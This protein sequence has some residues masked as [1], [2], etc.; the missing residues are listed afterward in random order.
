MATA[1]PQQS[2]G[3]AITV[4]SGRLNTATLLQ[5]RRAAVL[6]LR[7][8]AKDYPASVASECL[9]NLITSLSNDGEDVDTVQAV[10]QT[11]LNFLQPN[12]NSLEAPEAAEDITLWVADEFAL[13]PENMALLLSFLE[14]EDLFSRLYTLQLLHMILS[15]RTARTEEAILAAP[16]GLHRLVA[17]LGDKRDV[18]RN[19]GIA[20]LTALTQDSSEL[21]KIAVFNDAFDWIFSII[22]GEGGLSDGDRVIEDCLIL[23]GNLLRNNDPNAITFREAGCVPHLAKLL[24][25]AHGLGNETEELATW[26]LEQQERNT[27]ALLAITRLFLRSA[28]QRQLNQQAFYASDG[29]YHALQLAF[30][31]AADTSIRAQALI[32]CAD[33]IA[34]NPRLQERFPQLQVP[35]VTVT[36]TDV[37]N[38][39]LS[40]KSVTLVYVIDALLEFAL[41]VQ[42]PAMF[43][44]RM[45]ACQCLKAYFN[46]HDEIRR[47]FVQQAVEGYRLGNPA[48][49]NV[50]AILAEDWFDPDSE[51]S[52]DP[53][54][55]WFAAVLLLNL[56]GESWNSDI[57]ESAATNG[58]SRGAKS[59]PPR[60]RSIMMNWRQTLGLSNNRPALGYSMLITTWLFKNQ[61]GIN[62]FLEEPENLDSLIAAV[63]SGDQGDILVQGVCAVMLGI[64]YD[65][66]TQESPVTRH[67]L[68]QIIQAKVTPKRFLDAV[69]SLRS[70]PSIRD[71]DD[72]PHKAGDAGELPQVYFDE[73]YVA[74]FQTYGDM[75]NVAIERGPDS[76][77]EITE[78]GEIIYVNR[79]LVEALRK[80]IDEKHSQWQ[81]AESRWGSIKQQLESERAEHQRHA[82]ELGRITGVNDALQR[83]HEDEVKSLQRKQEEE[84]R[85]LQRQIEDAARQNKDLTK[86]LENRRKDIDELQRKYEESTRG[87]QRKDDEIKSTR[88]ANQKQIE[89]MRQEA[90]KT[91]EAANAEAAEKAAEIQRQLDYL[92]KSSEAEAKRI[93]RRTEAEVADLR[94]TI[95]RQ[96]VE[97]M[98]TSKAHSQELQSATQELQT[99]KQELQTVKQ[100][101]QTA[102][103]ELKTAKQELQT[104]KQE[105]TTKDKKIKEVEQ[106]LRQLQ[107]K[108]DEAQKAGKQSRQQQDKKAEDKIREL[109]SKL[110]DAEKRKAQ[111][112][113]QVSK[114]TS[115]LKEKDTEK[116]ATQTELDDLLMV[117]GDLEEKAEKYKVS[118]IH[119]LTAG[120]LFQIC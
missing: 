44:L 32:T 27:Y 116:A 90:Q 60:I 42:S 12:Q 84:I 33:T 26:A 72:T 19:E 18:V 117:F 95:S 81:D 54:H 111:N 51:A 23:L 77:V 64:I 9:K 39:K 100:E 68:Y 57:L 102:K 94:A 16:L 107:D 28:S 79:P 85:S 53:Y 35:S 52:S 46:H 40:G 4:L 6:S 38:G 106:K 15:V 96:E 65:F 74:F 76:E 11:I 30:S 119:R 31:Q 118:L 108:L 36:N 43:P 70:H 83:H 8:L 112:E 63:L 50:L 3:R 49:D 113:D 101:L 73:L 7:G 105:S 22:F 87:L 59:S 71:F 75:V 120:Y 58:D 114:L 82:A 110:K 1:P 78:S 55:Y 47:H 69:W 17:V 2:A 97:I 34:D 37:S 104:A 88:A 21:Q 24:K 25:S 86:N 80:T 13:R 109:E 20:L 29:L 91:A 103:Q 56:M 89:S 41:N 45:A 48:T 93:Q 14:Q 67:E 61:V 99:T 92:K 10:L 66:S 98:K 5:D 62:M 115:Q